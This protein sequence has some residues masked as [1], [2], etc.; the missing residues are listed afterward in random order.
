LSSLRTA[1]ERMNEPEEEGPR[2]RGRSLFLI[3]V[4]LLVLAALAAWGILE[5]PWGAPDP[6]STA[7][8]PAVPGAQPTG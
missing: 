3:L 7:A 6:A 1:E 4:L 5:G 2:G 8:P